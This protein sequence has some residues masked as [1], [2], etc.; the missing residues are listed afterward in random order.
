MLACELFFMSREP[1]PFLK[2]Q[3]IPKR[4]LAKEKKPAV[5]HG[6]LIDL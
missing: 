5:H 4:R 6:T 1:S 3:L 2:T